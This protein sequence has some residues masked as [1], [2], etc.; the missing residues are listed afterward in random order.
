[1]RL[2]PLI[3]GIMKPALATEYPWMCGYFY[4]VAQKTNIFS[5][6]KIGACHLPQRDS[7][8]STLEKCEEFICKLSI[9]CIHLSSLKDIIRVV[10]T[11]GNLRKGQLE[12]CARRYTLKY[13]LTYLLSR[14][15]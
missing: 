2:Y 13:L 7:G 15:E 1:M 8:V 9:C 12:V 5:R 11:F 6:R 10:V 14:C 3:D 4:S